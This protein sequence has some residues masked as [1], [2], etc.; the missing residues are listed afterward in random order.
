[1]SKHPIIHTTRESFLDATNWKTS[2]KGNLYIQ[3]HD[4]T[5]TL[6]VDFVSPDSDAESFRCVIVGP[7]GVRKD[8]GPFFT[9][10]ELK[11]ALWPEGAE[12][13]LGVE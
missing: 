3:D 1:M 5:Y 7:G 2:K 11:D 12:R 6:K 4:A 10:E 8:I 9:S 13:P